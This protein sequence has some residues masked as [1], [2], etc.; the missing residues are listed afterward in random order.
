MAMMNTLLEVSIN[1]PIL[2]FGVVIVVII[3]FVCAGFK[4][5]YQAEARVLE[6]LG[7]YRCTWLTGIHF[8]F[9]LVE[10]LSPRISLKEQIEDYEPQ[11]VITKDNIIMEID[12]VVFYQITDCKLYTYGVVDP[13]A[14]MANLTATTL[15]NIIGELTLDETLTSR[16]FI[17]T[18]M[19]TLLDEATDPWGIKVNRVELRDI[20]LPPQIQQAME[21]EMKAERYRRATVLRAEGEAEAILKVQEATARG[22]QMINESAPSEAVITLKSLEAFAK[23]A[24]GQATKIIIP[25]NIQGIAGLATALTESVIP[26]KS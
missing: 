25:S 20:A 4:V 23:A 17:N 15:R 3:A 9:P 22:I 21:E 5:V 12:T 14:A 1:L 10:T 24:D 8:K 6:F 18:K 11:P 19:R 7:R 16:D 2:V 13:K 26:P